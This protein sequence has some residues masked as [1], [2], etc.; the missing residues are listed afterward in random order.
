VTHVRHQ[1]FEADVGERIAFEHAAQQLVA[2][3]RNQ[4]RRAEQF[5]R[6]QAGGPR[7]LGLGDAIADHRVELDQG[8]AR[9]GKVARPRPCLG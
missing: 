4:P 8:D 7:G 2:R 5:G 3:E 6:G 1:A 9:R